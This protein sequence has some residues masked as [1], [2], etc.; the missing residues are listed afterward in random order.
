M[1]EVIESIIKNVLTA[2]YQPFW[3]AISLSV[4]FMFVY[5]SYDS[6]KSAAK[7]WIIWFRTDVEFRKLFLLVFFSVMVLFRTLFNRNMWMNPLSKVLGGWWIYNEDGK[8]TTES[9][10]N[11]IMFVPFTIMYLWNNHRRFF[12]RRIYIS[13]TLWIA[14]KVTFIFSFTI[15]MLQLFLRVGTWQISDLF[16]NTLGGIAGGAIYFVVCYIKGIK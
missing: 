8:L 9:I 15:E 13:R 4:L 5:K 6:V 1:L 12:R 10:E 11:F 16:Y 14:A 3:F 2:L 7:Q